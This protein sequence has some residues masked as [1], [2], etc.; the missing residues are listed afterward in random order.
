M[1]LAA[2]LQLAVEE[3]NQLL[4]AA[5]FGLSQAD[6]I[7]NKIIHAFTSKDYASVE[8]LLLPQI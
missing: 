1:I 3:L 6:E 8:Q 5:D 2:Q 4:K 7:E